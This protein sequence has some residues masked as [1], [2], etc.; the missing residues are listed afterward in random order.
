MGK[1]NV[2][3][4]VHVLH[5][6]LIMVALNTF[7]GSAG[8]ARGDVVLVNFDD[9]AASTSGSVYSSNA[10]ASHGVTLA[11]C[12]STSSVAV[13]STLNLFG[14][15]PRVWVFGYSNNAPSPPNYVGAI[16]SANGANST[17][18]ILLSFSTPIF[19]IEV[20]TDI[21]VESGEIV[22]LLALEPTANPWEFEVVGLAQGLDN[23]TSSPAN[24]LTVN[25]GTQAFSYALFQVT[26]EYEC[27]DSLTFLPVPEPDAIGACLLALLL[28][29]TSVRAIRRRR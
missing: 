25:M 12:I 9:V 5:F 17:N 16:N 23:A 18:D 8:I 24:L 28:G 26:T 3:P 4:R 20:A 2:S 10:F 21:P 1:N 15:D 6:I 14:I 19:S 7:I 11:S 29:G 13:G 27:I 22:R